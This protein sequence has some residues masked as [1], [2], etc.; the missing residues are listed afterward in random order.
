MQN[1][2]KTVKKGDIVSFN[3]SGKY[4]V[5]FTETKDGEKYATIENL[6]NKKMPSISTKI[7]SLSPYEEEIPK[8]SGFNVEKRYHKKEN[9]DI[10]AVNFTKR[11]ERADFLA[12][13]KKAKEAGGY[14]SSFGKG[15]FIFETEEAANNFGRTAINENAKE[16]NKLPS[17]VT[18]EGYISEDGVN[19]TVLY[20]GT[21]DSNVVTISQL[22]AGKRRKDGE[23]ATFNGE[24]IYFA[25]DLSVAK[26]YAGENGNIIPAYIN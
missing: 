10:Y 19:K 13:K 18:T 4:E 15:G 24:G 1:K 2:N 14:Y 3:G 20:H 12:A 8:D 17:H 22:E 11:M 16:G 9:K 25:T 7:D 21:P 5:L 26:D 6:E 23:K